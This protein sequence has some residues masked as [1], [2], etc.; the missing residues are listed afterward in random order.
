MRDATNAS[1]GFQGSMDR[2]VISPYKARDQLSTGMLARLARRADKVTYYVDPGVSVAQ[3]CE[4]LS[5]GCNIIFF[6]SSPRVQV[7]CFGRVWRAGSREK[8]TYFRTSTW[9][10]LRSRSWVSFDDSDAGLDDGVDMGFLA[11]A[12][13]ARGKFQCCHLMF[14]PKQEKFSPCHR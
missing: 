5:I 13:V 1:S 12:N 14:G 7:P 8:A 2:A 6:S 3:A 11:E 10:L 4:R 9:Y